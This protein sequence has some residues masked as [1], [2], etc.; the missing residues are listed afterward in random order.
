[1]EQS[2]LTEDSINLGDVIAA[3][4]SGDRGIRFINVSRKSSYVTLRWV[5][6]KKAADSVGLS[7]FL[8]QVTEVG[9]LWERALGG[10]LILHLPQASAFDADREFKRQIDQHSGPR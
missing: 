9:G 5:I 10:V 2:S 3:E 8:K 4:L 1:M 6:S 7:A